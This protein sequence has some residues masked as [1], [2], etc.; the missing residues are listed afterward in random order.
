M[1]TINLSV[2]T[3]WQTFHDT[4]LTSCSPNQIGSMKIAFYAG[5]ASMMTINQKLGMPDTSEEEGANI[6]QACLNEIESFQNS[7]KINTN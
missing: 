1:A 3:S 2:N 4:C 6:L 5:V 7:L